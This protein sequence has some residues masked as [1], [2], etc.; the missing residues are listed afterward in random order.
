MSVVEVLPFVPTTCTAGKRRCGSPSAA[1]SARMRPSPNSSGHGDRPSSQA[2]SSAV[3][4]RLELAAVAL[5]LLA[6]RLDDLRR[7]VLHEP[8]VPEHLLRAGDLL[9]QA[10]SLRVD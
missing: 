2:I 1:R 10:V 9:P 5:E 4:E 8:L 7:R 3:A 6:L